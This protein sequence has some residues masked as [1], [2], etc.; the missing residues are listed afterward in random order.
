MTEPLRRPNLSVFTMCRR[1]GGEQED[2]N[3]AVLLGSLYGG[4]GSGL[5]GPRVWQALWV[6]VTALGFT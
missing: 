3:P 4:W 5:A 1:N 6:M 2:R